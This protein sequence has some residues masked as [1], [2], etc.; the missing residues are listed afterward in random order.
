MAVELIITK[1][2]LN[3]K[4]SAE[5]T[6]TAIEEA[7]FWSSLPPQCPVCGSGL[8]FRHRAGRGKLPPFKAYDYKELVCLGVPTSHYVQLHKKMDQS[9]LYYIP[10]DPWAIVPRS[11][12]KG[13]V[14]V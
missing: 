12:S 4:V 14:D 2:W 5:S 3:V 6:E 9:G 11:L 8:G 1:P 10:E 13:T 7:A